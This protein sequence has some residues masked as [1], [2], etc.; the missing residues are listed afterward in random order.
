MSVKLLVSL[1]TS[2]LII[3]H[4]Y[5]L[6]MQY[7]AKAEAQRSENIAASSLRDAWVSL[8]PEL[9][10]WNASYKLDSS[11][12]DLNGIFGAL[13]LSD[14]NLQSAELTLVDAGRSV[15]NFN[16][17]PIGLTRACIN[18]SSAGFVLRNESVGDYIKRLREFTARLD[19]EYDTLTV[20]M[21]A[22]KDFQRPYAYFGRLCVLLRGQDVFQEEAIE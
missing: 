22:A 21:D 8:E 1:A 19:I 13:R 3:Y 9:Q 4:G 14:H 18:N 11:I 12:R 5:S 16:S 7:Q 15:I 17:A 10:Q 20:K 6:Q 2:L